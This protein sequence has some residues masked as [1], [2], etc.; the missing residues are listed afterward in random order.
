[1]VNLTEYKKTS[2]KEIE[3]AIANAIVQV[4]NDLES[5]THKFKINGTTDNFYV[6]EDNISW[7]SGFWTGQIWI[8]YEL[9]G[10][11]KFKDAAEVQVDSFLHRIENKIETNNH[12]MGFLYS[13]SCVAAYKLTSNKKAKKAAILAA[14]NLITRYQKNGKFIQAWGNVGADDNYRL[15]IDCLLNLPLLYW[16]SDVTGDEK[17]A[18]IAKQHINTSLK[19]I[20]REDYSTYHT[21]YFEKGTGK[22]LYGETRQGY[23]NDS[24]WSRGQAWG[25]YGTALSYM[26]TKNKDYIDKFYN[27]T[28]FFIKNL[29][30]D[31]VP[32][33][34]FNFNDG[35]DEPK[36]SSAAAIAV[37]GMLEMAKYL[38]EEK[39]NYYKDV[40]LKIL[41]SLI[42]NYAV[43]NPN[44]S[45]GQLLHGVYARKS[46]YNP[47]KNRNVNECNTWGDYY[48]LEALIRLS[49]DWELYW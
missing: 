5:F 26:Y 3:Q 27:I 8:A 18:K 2:D 41:K 20:M 40:A 19:V 44:I 35:S 43:S 7:T 12:D 31:L 42:D 32:Y 11:Q 21:F 4:E 34:D 14:D 45:N 39:A 22:P 49:K 48:Y 24:A 38:D 46:P 10:C 17:Y 9:T 16:A 36:D 1:M 47:C 13:L 28:D 33:W 6:P 30:K 37:C 29:P 25:I 23:S 15:I